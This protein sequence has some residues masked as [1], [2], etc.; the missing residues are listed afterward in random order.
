MNAEVIGVIT[1][2]L[3]LAAIAAG[4]HVSEDHLHFKNKENYSREIRSTITTFAQGILGESINF[5]RKGQLEVRSSVA[6]T[7]TP[8]TSANP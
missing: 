7:R 6:E 3:L 4:M 2:A 5:S 8:T 1:F